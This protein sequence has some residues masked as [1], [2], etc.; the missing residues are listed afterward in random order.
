VRARGERAKGEKKERTKKGITGRKIRASSEREWTRP[1]ERPRERERRSFLKTA[2]PSSEPLLIVFLLLVAALFVFF[3]SSTSSAAGVRVARWPER[4]GERATEKAIECARARA[5][6]LLR[7]RGSVESPRAVVLK[8]SRGT[9][10]PSS[11]PAELPPRQLRNSI[12]GHI[13]CTRGTSARYIEDG[14]SLR[15]QEETVR[16][17]HR[18]IRRSRTIP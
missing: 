12:G 4:A 9:R 8:V 5:L 7:V 11:R 15:V 17:V 2:S 14:G 16:L 18:G 13:H 6:S 1:W 10:S 3:A